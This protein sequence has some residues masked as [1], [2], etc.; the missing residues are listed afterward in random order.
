MLEIACPSCGDA[1]RFRSESSVYSTCFSCQSLLVRHDVDVELLGKVADLQPDGTPIQIGTSG[2]FDGAAFEVLGR[3]Q[4]LH[5]EG[6]WNEW[7]LQFQD[8]R[9]GWLGEA[10]GEYFVSSLVQTEPQSLPGFADLHVGKALRV[11]S[12]ELV[13]TNLAQARVVSFQGELPFV[14]STEY[15]LPFA[16]LRSSG[17]TGATLDYSEEQPLLFVGAF[18]DFEEL[19]FRGLRDPEEEAERRSAADAKVLRCPNCGAPHE[20]AGGPRTQTLVCTFCDAGIDLTDP[21]YGLLWKAQKARKEEPGI[22]LGSKG[23]LDGAVWECLG[24]QRRFVR[25]EGVDYYWSEYVCYNRERGYR[26]LVESSGHWTWVAPM[27]KLPTASDGRPVHGWPPQDFLMLDGQKFKHFQS[28]TGQVSYVVGEFPWRV[29]VEDSAGL[30]DYICPP[31]ILSAEVTSDGMTWSLGRYL[32]P[33]E[34]WSAFGLS[35]NPPARTGVGANQP[36][37]LAGMLRTAWMQYAVFFLVG[38]LMMIGFSI[39]SAQAPVLTQDFVAVQGEEPSVVTRPFKLEGRTSNLVVRL[40]TNLD[41][42]WAY[43]DMALINEETR[44]ARIFSKSVS[45]YHGSSGGESWREGS[46][47]EET[48][49]PSVPSGTYV[50]RLEPQ[51]GTGNTPD[52]LSAKGSTAGQPVLKY[53]VRLTRDVPSWSYLWFVMV[54]LAIYP[55]LVWI[56][57]GSFEQKRWLESDHA[58]GDSSD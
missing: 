57:Y 39:L 8:G 15:E 3:I 26:Y 50:L 47:T 44:Q 14:M 32:E 45:Y 56:R 1:V 53:G 9:H 46:R 58:P 52:N 28:A 36:S 29:K 30:H 37:P 41:N 55:I 20:L 6:Y 17:R 40:Q 51:T 24:F 35:G 54:V 5:P 43:F 18:R 42:R 2:V 33:E 12:R 34:V 25:I 7:F 11:G 21:N 13:V 27:H 49:V 31:Q 10:M 38:F 19:Q 48:T 4:I 22:P 23:N 16:D